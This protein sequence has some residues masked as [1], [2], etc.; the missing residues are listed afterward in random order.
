MR[1][2]L[3]KKECRKFAQPKAKFDLQSGIFH[4]EQV[5]FVVTAAVKI[6]DRHK[7]LVCSIFPVDKVADGC[8]FP[9]WSIRTRGKPGGGN[10]RRMHYKTGTISFES[11]H[12]I[13]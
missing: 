13:K 6:I 8:V 1:Q 11:V 3:N 4:C 12:F 7:T 2:I 5:K 10:V 9:P